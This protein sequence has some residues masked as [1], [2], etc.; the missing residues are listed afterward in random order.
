MTIPVGPQ[1]YAV[2]LLLLKGNRPLGVTRKD[3]LSDWGMPG[4][5][6]D[7]GESLEEACARELLEETGLVVKDLRALI[8]LFDGYCPTK[9]T[10]LKRVVTYWTPESNIQ[11]EPTK[12]ESGDVNW[13]TWDQLFAGSFGYYNVGVAT[14]HAFAHQCV[15][16]GLA[17]PL[18]LTSGAGS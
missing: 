18:L 11:G 16:Q 10:S 7:P 14:A 8:P 4:G 12:V 13:V 17:M 2:C 5:K 3:D 15:Q 9:D 1:P 6:V